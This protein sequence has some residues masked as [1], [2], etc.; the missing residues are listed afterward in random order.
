MSYQKPQSPELPRMIGVCGDIGHGKDTVADYL[1]EHYGYRQ[2]SWSE[3]L[4]RVCFA[5]YQ[6]LGAERRHFFG[7][8]ADKAEELPG[9]TDPSGKPATGRGIMEHIG[10]E[11]FRY[12]DRATWVKVGLAVQVDVLPEIRWVVSDVRFANEFD[13]IHSRDGVVWQAIKVG[14]KDHGTGHQSDVGWRGLTKDA[15]LMAKAGDL[16]ALRLAVDEVMMVGGREHQR[17]LSG[18]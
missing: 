10:T 7:T 11:G 8:Q 12:V 18:E 9:I 2:L 3:P 1:V 15:L 4:K 14:G 5:V 13:A 17:L 6:H 16:E